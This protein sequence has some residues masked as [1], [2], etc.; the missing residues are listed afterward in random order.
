MSF[1]PV[2]LDDFENY[3]RENMAPASYAYY[4]TGS[5]SE[6]TLRRNR[7]VYS[8]LLIRPKILI[9]VEKVSTAT[10][11]LGQK[12]SIP[13]C[14][15]PTAYHGLAHHEGELASAKATAAMD[16]LYCLST[17][18]GYSI[19]EVAAAANTRSKNALQW[20]QLYMEKD[21]SLTERLVRRCEAAGFKAIVVTTD[22]PRLGPR[23]RPARSGFKLPQH[24]KRANFDSDN[25]GDQD[26]MSGEM[27][28]GMTWREIIW[29]KS[30]TK[31]P[32]VIK[33]IFRAEDAKMAIEHGVDAIVVSNHGGRQLD[34]C[35]STLEVL[36]E[37]V[38]ACRG[39]RIEVY[40]DGGIRSGTDVFKALAIGAR[41]VFIGRPILYGLAY[42]GE[43]GVKQVLSMIGRDFQLTMALAGCA[44]VRPSTNHLLYLTLV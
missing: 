15:A 22:R 35:P 32:V 43:A 42:K 12:I 1:L 20:F 23:L 16:T 6:E 21:K 17:N 4:S 19:S 41:A 36:P 2:S 11:V 34:S 30:I 8:K 27:F 38:Q 44:D 40:V 33:G 24:L 28:P 7:Q 29:L 5:S 26:Y 25:D 3:A 37:I 18:S 14:V 39:S 31:L 13:I 9:D 10:T